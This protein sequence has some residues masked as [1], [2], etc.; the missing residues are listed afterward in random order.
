MR[1]LPTCRPSSTTLAARREG[2]VIFAVLIVVVVLSL[3]AY[4]FADSMTAEYR[5]GVRTTDDAQVKLAAVSGLH[6]T[7]AVLSD[8][9]TFYGDLDGEPFDNPDIF[10]EFEVQTSGGTA[11]PNRRT[12]FSIRS[13]AMVDGGGVE[14]RYGV[15]D[16]GGKLNINS[17]IA[18]DPTGELLYNALMKL[19]PLGMLPETADA[20]VD[21]VDAD[22]DARA[23]GAESSYYQSLTN[24]YKS[25]N[26][27]LN[28]LDELLLVKGVDPTLLYGGDRNRNGVQDEGEVDET[29]GL[30][31][32]LTV[33]G[34]ELNVDM[35]GT[36]RIYLN[37]DSLETLYKQLEQAVGSELA[38]YIVASKVF[39]PQRNTPTTFTAVSSGSGGSTTIT[40]STTGKSQNQRPTELATPEMLYQ[41]VQAQITATGTSGKRVRSLMDLM[42]TKITLPRPPGTPNETPDYVAYSPLDDPAKRNELLTKLLD[43]T[44]VR[45]AIEMVPRLNVNTASREVLLSV[46][47]MTEDLVQKIMDRRLTQ[48][49]TDPGTVSGAWL[50][51]TDTMTSAQYKQMEKYITGS[52]MVYRVQSIGYFAGGGPVARMEAVIDT[53]QGAPRFLY[54]R[55]LSDLENPRGFQ[56]APMTNQ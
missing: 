7:A 9:E 40:F 3:V 21:W 26:G 54:I 33:Y 17:L 43:K 27:P 48:L 36:A 35:S 6:Y 32:Y 24:P 10:Q 30:S 51:T 12:F 41:A 56:P 8:R 5:A 15:I 50:V 38:T 1:L 11:N 34:R 25:K 16:E 37:G 31:D 20:I 53:N 44:T 18:L 23:S 28:S 45:Q 47:N 49:P 19:E 39:S 55:D 29:R 2:Y 22:D 13:V 4:R 14:Q 42:G 52:T 46:P